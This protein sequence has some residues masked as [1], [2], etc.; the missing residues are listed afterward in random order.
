MYQQYDLVYVDFQ[1][2]F[3]LIFLFI[4]VSFFVPPLDSAS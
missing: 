3:V 4:Y 2:F 1:V